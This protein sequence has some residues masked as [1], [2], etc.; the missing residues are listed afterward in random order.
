M[1]FLSLHR[2]YAKRDAQNV[3][4]F[5]V[6][7]VDG[8]YEVT[9]ES[10]DMTLRLRIRDAYPKTF[11]VGGEVVSFGYGS[12]GEDS[13]FLIGTLY[14]DGTIAIIRDE[15]VTLPIFYSFNQ[16]QFELSNVYENIV[17]RT[18]TKTINHRHVVNV[19]RPN[20]DYHDTLY[21]EIKILDERMAINVTAD[22][23]V[24]TKPADRIWQV[25]ADTPATDPKDFQRVLSRHLETFIATR[26]EGNAVAFEVSAGI[27]SSLLP[28]YV[29]SKKTN[30]ITTG[31]MVF[32]GE[33]KQ[34]QLTKRDLIQ[35]GKSA[36]SVSIDPKKDYPLSRFIKSTERPFYSFE[37]IYTESLEKLAV[38]LAGRGVEVVSTGIGGDEL[39]ENNVVL[40]DEFQFGLATMTARA[41]VTLPSYFTDTFRKQW[42]ATTPTVMPY[43]VPFLGVSL[44]GAQ[45]ARNA[46]YIAHDIWPVSPFASSQLYEFCQGLPAIYRS[47]KNILRAYYDAHNFPKEISNPSIN[48]NFGRFFDDCLSSGIY[49]HVVAMYAEHSIIEQ[50]GYLD[51]K[52]LL[53]EWQQKGD[54]LTDPPTK[55]LL[56]SIFAWLN[57]EMN[58]AA[59]KHI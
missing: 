31:T 30:A 54:P 33:Y 48:E 11:C 39:F 56:F 5:L 32:P 36:V 55:Q 34:S 6:A 57:L 24:I 19:L 23:A 29:K 3:S 10:G 2:D 18:A 4:R 8:Y 20:P 58:V 46:I 22:G 12:V 9:T 21:N 45:L 1:S 50:W 15:Y 51:A 44:H 59:S 7:E 25:T 38:S 37:E 52:A 16:G 53:H 40:E 13:E 47:N 26:L 17:E 42:I 14:Q 35:S 43:T 49:D 41:E 27:D 28:L